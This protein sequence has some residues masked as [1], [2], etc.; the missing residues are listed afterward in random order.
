MMKSIRKGLIIFVVFFIISAAFAGC[1]ILKRDE[2]KKIKDNGNTK[3]NGGNLEEHFEISIGFWEVQYGFLNPEQDALLQKMQN[4]FNITIK[5]VHVSW[6]NYQ[7]R[8]RIL[9]VSGQLPD[10]SAN[11]IV[12]TKTYDDWIQ[13]GIIRSVP[14]EFINKY[15]NVKRI[16]ELPDVKNLRVNG[17][18]YMIPRASF[19]DRDL[20]ASAAALLVR[21]DWMENLGIRDPQNFDEFVAMLK[22]F[23]ENDPD[24]NGLNDTEGLSTNNKQSFGKWVIL[25]IHPQF[26]TY[27]WVREGDRFVPSCAAKDFLDVILKLKRLYK[28]G[29]L[30]KDFALQ[31]TDS[32]T[33]KFARGIVG[34]LEYQ[35]SPGA[36]QQIANL[37][38]EYNPG[39]KFSE[40]VK[41]LRV[42]PA[43]DG[44]L[45]HNTGLHF[46]SE[47]YFSSK[48]DDGKMDRILMLYDYLLSDEGQKMIKLGI[49][50][51]DYIEEGDKITVLRPKDENT[52]RWVELIKLY[53]SLSMFASLASWGSATIEEFRNNE[54]NRLSYDEDILKMAQEEIEWN[55]KYTKPVPRVYEIMLLN[56]PAKSRFSTVSIVDDVIKVILDDGDPIE[57]WNDVL[58]RYEK[59]GMNEA[60]EEVNADAAEMGIIPK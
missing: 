35:S 41:L 46:W 5:P 14:D 38:N 4:E 54:I 49:E 17:N 10:I 53:P 37:W 40:H 32:G 19:L 8:Y 57:L 55:L 33:E 47:S 3:I 6:S 30:D 36:L 12:N 21:K 31:R 26:N 25:T 7:E 1:S 18:F 24:Q 51:K 45:Y 16:M 23:S 50:K 28:E 43:E 58:K 27:S 56:T 52:G 59:L 15:S 48:V 20:F 29:A 34:A 60:I 13:Q 9:A 2:R 42:F 11:T 44:N 22:A 39:K